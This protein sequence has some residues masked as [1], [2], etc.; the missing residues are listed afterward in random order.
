MGFVGLM[1]VHLLNVGAASTR[2]L[3]ATMVNGPVLEVQ[4][5]WHLDHQRD[6]AR[7]VNGNVTCVI[8]FHPKTALS[9]FA[10]ILQWTV[11]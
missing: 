10:R 2:D 1:P 4:S 3:A 6:T 8:T 5:I 11:P 7:N 9:S